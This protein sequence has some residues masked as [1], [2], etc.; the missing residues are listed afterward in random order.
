[1]QL[2]KL[3]Q[4]FFSAIYAPEENVGL[5]ATINSHGNLTTAEKLA[6][7]RRSIITGFLHALEAA[8]PVCHKLVGNDFFSAMA[9]H[10]ITINPATSSDLEDYGENFANFIITFK[11]AQSLPYL[12]D[13][14]HLEWACH[15]AIN[16]APTPTLN[17]QALAKLSTEQQAKLIF[18]LPTDCVFLTSPFPIQRIWE[19]NQNNYSGDNSV[20]LDMGAV[21]LLVWRLNMNLRIDELSLPEWTLLQLLSQQRTLEEIAATIDTAMIDLSVLLP[22]LMERGWL[23]GFV[24]RG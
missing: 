11:P 24:L 16:A 19:V 23:R 1:M 18:Q 21:R 10:Y 22:R 4:Q 2:K 6:I 3:Q 20:N 5:T 9:R 15:K 8:Y 13:V 14:A 7:Y 12:A 17:I